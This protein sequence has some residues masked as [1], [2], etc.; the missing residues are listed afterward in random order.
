MLY[1]QKQIWFAHNIEMQGGKKWAESV[2]Q[3]RLKEQN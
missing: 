3:T 1:W 2:S